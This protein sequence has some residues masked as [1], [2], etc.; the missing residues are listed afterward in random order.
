MKSYL[1]NV[2]IYSTFIGA[3]LLFDAGFMN[4]IIPRESRFLPKKEIELLEDK[5]RDAFSNP[6]D[7]SFSY[8]KHEQNF[9][10]Y[11]VVKIPSEEIMMG[12]LEIGILQSQNG[13]MSFEHFS[14]DALVAINGSIFRLDNDMPLGL[15]VS[16]ITDTLNNGKINLPTKGYFL[17]DENGFKITDNLDSSRTYSLVLESFPIIINDYKKTKIYETEAAPRSVV[18]LDS[19]DDLYFI[20]TSNGFLNGATIKGLQDFL[21]YKGFKSALNLDGGSSTYLKAETNAGILYEYGRSDI[22]NA[23]I[24]K[25]GK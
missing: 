18:A 23:I 13:L 7:L 2:L 1:K 19:L 20:S 15:V 10:K 12:N 16:S 21:E 8:F 17:L 6:I 14:K 11:N 9:T 3:G 25:R 5:K 24:I 4:Q 22:K